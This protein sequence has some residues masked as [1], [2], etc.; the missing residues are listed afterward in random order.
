[1]TYGVSP[2]PKDAMS[3]SRSILYRFHQIHSRIS[4]YPTSPSQLRD[5]KKSARTQRHATAQIPKYTPQ[6]LLLLL[7]LP[8][9]L[10]FLQEQISNAV[11]GNTIQLTKHTICC[12]RRLKPDSNPYQG[13]RRGGTKKWSSTHYNAPGSQVY[14]LETTRKSDNIRGQKLC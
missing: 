4:R 13:I 2:S 10:P 6:P 1:M 14:V 3:S 12:H 5:T 8:L 11:N 9:P 7:L